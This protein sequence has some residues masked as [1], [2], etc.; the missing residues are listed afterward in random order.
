M[1]K[2]PLY[3]ASCS[4][5]KDSLAAIA[6]RVEQ[7]KKV[8]TALYCRVMFDDGISA[9]F[10]EHEEWIHNHAIPLLKA[11]YGVHTVIV[12]SPSTYCRQFYTRYGRGVKS[13]QYYGFPMLRGPWCNS[14]LKL[15]PLRKW[16]RENSPYISILGIAADEF[17]RIQRSGAGERLLP[18]VERG[19]TEKE[20]FDFCRKRDL[21][22]PA[23]KGGR[24]RL[25]CWFC[26]NQ[27]IGELRRLRR[28]YPVLW[29]RLLDMEKD[30]FR[31]FKPNR[32]LR[33]FDE[34]FS[35]EDAQLCMFK[36][37]ELIAC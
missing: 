17:V 8:D 35:N 6:L 2:K 23:Y 36:D 27:R 10:P 16:Q 13:G 21:L 33:E 7:G 18:L 11:R 5:G 28:E 34:Q 4:F 29:R 30:S 12:Q 15:P 19:M 20:C 32:T 25:G 26:H 1:N 24:M 3:I 31:T 22:S 9:E 37:K 14:R